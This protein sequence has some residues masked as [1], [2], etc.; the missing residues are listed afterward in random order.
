LKDT[1][2]AVAVGGDPEEAQAI[3][4][5]TRD[6]FIRTEDNDGPVRLK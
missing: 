4:D 3:L 6:A 1:A 2:Y 5:A